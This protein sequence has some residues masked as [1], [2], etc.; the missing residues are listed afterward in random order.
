MAA[1]GTQDGGGLHPLVPPPP[2]D[3]FAAQRRG[4]EMMAAA[5]RLAVGW[6][7]ATVAMHRSAT[8]R[9]LARMTETARTLAA[10]TAPDQAEAMMAQLRAA[11][12]EG[13][14]TAE[15]IAGLIRRIQGE[16]LTAL[17]RALTV[18]KP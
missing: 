8:Q 15:E 4:L 5:N 13:L 17:E 2:A 18:G 16:A 1:D 7:E 14:Q 12:A 10:G 11:Q 6:M 9:A 3:P